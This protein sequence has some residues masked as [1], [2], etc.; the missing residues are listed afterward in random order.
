ML[1]LLKNFVLSTVL[2][3]ATA[4]T[5]AADDVTYD[6]ILANPDDLE[7][8]YLYAQQQVIKGDLEQASAALERL[9]LL[10]PNWDSARLF[11][12]LVL[13]RLDDMAGA[14]RELTIL[15]DR[16]L[17]P[18]QSREVN[19][20]LAL[21]TAQSKA[22]RLTGRIATG[23]RVDS[24]PDLTTNSDND[25]NGNPLDTDKRV[26]GAFQAGATAR[27]EHDIPGGG[28]NFLFVQGATD[29]NEQFKV[30]EADYITGGVKA[31]ATFFFEDLQITPYGTVD[32]LWLDGQNYRNDNGGGA[33]AK[34]AINPQ[35]TVFAGGKGVF[36]NYQIVSTDS[37]G[38]ARNGWLAR[39]TGGVTVRPT[40]KSRFTAR[41]SG[42]FKDARN[43]SYSYDALEIAANALVLIGQGQYV[44][45]SASYRWQ[46]YEQPDPNYSAT[47]TREDRRFKTRL[48]YGAPLDLLLE[49]VNIT[50]S[51]VTSNVNLQVG[52]NYLNQNSNIP[53]FD[54]DSVS[55]DIMLIKRFA[56]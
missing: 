6:Q 31:G 8:N 43:D 27:I 23:L 13:Y 14:K 37:V 54:A 42:S 50:G 44:L 22:T 2:L 35:L 20:Y 11:Y 49:K 32:T 51:E 5:A 45:A 30:D 21:A 12:A 10:Q 52:V 47:V 1:K 36:Q 40:E 56:N 41:V 3:I 18:S 25:L 15:S 29:L 16:P 19:R 24:N 26:D 48:A 28:G 7:L 39:A 34:Y 4:T 17:S 9:L 33:T 53:N 55:A 46:D 38:S